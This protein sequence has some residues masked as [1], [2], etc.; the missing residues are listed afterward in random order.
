MALSATSL[1]T[2]FPRFQNKRC[3]LPHNFSAPQTRSSRT[4]RG[5]W[6]K[7]LSTADTVNDICGFSPLSLDGGRAKVSAAEIRLMD[8][9]RWQ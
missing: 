7:T 9:C 4:I 5:E 3:D 1:P 8:D 2:L 6:N